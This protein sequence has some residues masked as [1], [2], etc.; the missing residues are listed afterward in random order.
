MYVPKYSTMW[1]WKTKQK[2]LSQLEMNFRDGV[3][4]LSML[5]F[6]CP[7]SWPLPWSFTS[8]ILKSATDELF[9]NACFSAMIKK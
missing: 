4:H 5:H 3:A 9:R 6:E 7:F 1:E 8:L 2:E